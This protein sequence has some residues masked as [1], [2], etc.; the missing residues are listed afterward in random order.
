ML[1]EELIKELKGQEIIFCKGLPGS[2][3][4]TWAKGFCLNNPTFVRINKDDVRIMLGN[5]PY[6]KKFEDSVLDVE[7]RIGL[8]IIENGLSLI[9]DDTN[10]APKHEKYW[11]II[12]AT[13]G[14]G[15]G[16]MEFHTPLEECIERDSEREKS[17]GKAVI[18]NMYNTYLKPKDE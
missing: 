8:A 14:I 16:V 2:G 3:K 17:V 7:R 6:S 11:S 4:S 12:A 5:L 1:D 13:R 18:L 10:F 9:V 15:F